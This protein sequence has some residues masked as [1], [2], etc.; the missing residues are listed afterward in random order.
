MDRLLVIIALLAPHRKLPG[1]DQHHRRPILPGERGGELGEDSS[2]RRR[3]AVGRRVRPL[4]GFG[5]TRRS[6]LRLRLHGKRL[7]GPGQP[8]AQPDRGQKD[9]QYNV[10]SVSH[11]L[12]RRFP[13]PHVRRVPKRARRNPEGRAEAPPLCRGLTQARWTRRGRVDLVHLVYLVRLV[14]PNKRDQPLLAL[15]ARDS[16]TNHHE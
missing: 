2:L 7:R 8:A 5:V 14:Q 10:S 1:G 13:L 3:P 9:R 16:A 4:Q 6:P 15:V 12:H 11:R